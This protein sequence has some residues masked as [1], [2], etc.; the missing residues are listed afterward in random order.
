MFSNILIFTKILF[1]Q[2]EL[3]SPINEFDPYQ[4]EQF[5]EELNHDAHAGTNFDLSLSDEDD[6]VLVDKVMEEEDTCFINGYCIEQPSVER[7]HLMVS[8]AAKGITKKVSAGAL[9]AYSFANS[10]K[11]KLQK[12]AMRLVSVDE[13]MPIMRGYGIDF[14][15]MFERPYDSNFCF[16]L[17][18][19][20]SRR[21]ADVGPEV[22][23]ID[24]P[25]NI[26]STP[27]TESGSWE[28]V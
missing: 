24:I 18:D 25:M 11:K 27:E 20:K 7:M 17:S 16:D 19:K 2:F 22:K 23:Y 14:C 21:N 5:Y 26:F 15:P 28:L 3:K 10:R 8:T 4:T 13:E 1:Q 12:K 9:S 6:V